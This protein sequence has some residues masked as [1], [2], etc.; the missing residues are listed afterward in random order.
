MT[1]ESKTQKKRRK[2][3]VKGCQNLASFFATITR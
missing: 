2:E 1:R 3:A